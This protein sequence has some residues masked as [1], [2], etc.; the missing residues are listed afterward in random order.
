[1]R[2]F[3]KHDEKFYAYYPGGFTK[4]EELVGKIAPTTTKEVQWVDLDKVEPLGT[5]EGEEEVNEV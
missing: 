5:P 4:G 2:Y 3:K 1:M